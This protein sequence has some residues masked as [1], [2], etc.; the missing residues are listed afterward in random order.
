MVTRL[1]EHLHTVAGAGD[2]WSVL[3]DFGG[4]TA[5][6]PSVIR[7]CRLTMECGRGVGAGRT[8]RL[9]GGLSIREVV[10][11][12][13]E[14]RRLTY[15]VVE[16]PLPCRYVRETWTVEP[17]E[18]SARIGATLEYG[19]GGGLLG[20]ALDRVLLRPFLRRQVRSGL[21]GLKRYV[22]R[23]PGGEAVAGDG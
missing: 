7:S 11:E 12:W 3:S 2:V 14:G 1:E 21:E 15:D 6:A 9:L 19:V 10:S 13:E 16:S 5:W 23:D 20:S 22:E 4:V 18:H 17:M 8:L